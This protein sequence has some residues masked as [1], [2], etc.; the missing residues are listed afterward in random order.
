[1]IE[2]CHRICGGLDDCFI[3]N[4]KQIDCISDILINKA[5]GTSEIIEQLIKKYQDEEL[6]LMLREAL[7]GPYEIINWVKYLQIARDLKFSPEP[8]RQSLNERRREIRYPLPETIQK[9]IDLSIDAHGRMLAGII[10][11]L[12]QQGLQ[13][14]TTEPVKPGMI[15]DLKL[16][17]TRATGKDLF[18]KIKTVY[19]NRNEDKFISGAFIV[20]MPDD[21]SFN[22]FK[23]VLDLL[24]GFPE[25]FSG[26]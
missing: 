4:K 9:Y 19:C 3:N 21:L 24:L 14:I 8:L 6:S 26:S 1:M 16:S 11:N 17:S 13:F 18:L 20:E 15:Y 10:T 22:F 7:R 5:F 23:N 25:K 2:R 12:S